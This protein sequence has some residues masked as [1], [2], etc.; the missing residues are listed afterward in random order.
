MIVGNIH[1]L[2]SGLPASLREAIDHVKAHVTEATP[3]EFA[4]HPIRV[5]ETPGHTLGHTT[6]GIQSGSA[7]LIVLG[8]VTNAPVF[9]L[10]NPGWHIAF[11]QDPVMAEASRPCCINS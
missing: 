10:N 6:Y 3:L 11:D 4:G 1:H 2:Q 7:T 5:L 8:D 9:N